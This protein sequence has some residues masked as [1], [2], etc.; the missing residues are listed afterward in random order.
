MRS[1]IVRL[2]GVGVVVPIMSIKVRRSMCGLKFGCDV[3]RR[4]ERLKER[5]G[6]GWGVWVYMAVGWM[7][8]NVFVVMYSIV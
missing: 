8:W 5:E 3:I 6:P 4:I 7:F 1:L 2:G